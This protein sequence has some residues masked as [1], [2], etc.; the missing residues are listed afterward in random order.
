VI[1]IVVEILDVNDH[2]PRFS[3]DWTTSGLTV[4]I[5]ESVLP[6]SAFSLPGAVDEDSGEFG[7]QTYELMSADQLAVPT[8]LP[9]RILFEPR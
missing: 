4:N 3:I 5:S 1:K 6:G 2:S 8:D 9:F 7:V